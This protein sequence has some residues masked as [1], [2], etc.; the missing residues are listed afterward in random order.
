MGKSKK[1]DLLKIL[2]TCR[3]HLKEGE[4][5]KAIKLGKITIQKYPKEGV[6]YFCLGLAYYSAGKLKSAYKNFKKAEKLVKDEEIL[7][8]IYESLGVILRHK[9]ICF[10]EKA[11][12]YYNKAWEL[13]KKV[14]DKKNRCSILIGMGL[15]N[16]Y[17][18]NVDDAIRCYEAV[19][20]ETTDK[21]N[22]IN[23][24][25]TL[26]VLYRTID[27]AKKAEFYSQKAEEL[28]NRK[29]FTF[30]DLFKEYLKDIKD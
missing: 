13:T 29:E 2:E 23:I 6:A 26:T 18:R 9:G 12:F 28:K 7:M 14:G 24:Y 5:K 16:V 27:D 20:E 11:L 4:Y 15:T 10:L 8:Q 30:D 25:N 3:K 1:T 22:K 21:T 17:R 19:L